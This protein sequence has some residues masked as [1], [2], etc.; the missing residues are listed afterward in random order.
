MMRLLPEKIF[1]EK[2]VIVLDKDRKKITKRQTSNFY[3]VLPF[4]NGKE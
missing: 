4:T 2:Q 1:D 3:Q